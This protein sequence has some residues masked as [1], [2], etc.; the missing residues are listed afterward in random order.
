MSEGYR[1][2]YLDNNK[3]GATPVGSLKIDFALPVRNIE[4]L[5][6]GNSFFKGSS[7]GESGAK[8]NE[9]GN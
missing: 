9:K 5:N 4:T 8:C 6:T 2:Q 7:F 3:A 1:V